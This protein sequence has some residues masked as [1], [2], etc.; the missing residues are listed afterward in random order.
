[1]PKSLRGEGRRIED[2]LKAEGRYNDFMHVVQRCRQIVAEEQK[3]ESQSPSFVVTSTDL[4]VH[5]IAELS[6]STGM[7]LALDGAPALA[8]GTGCGLFAAAAAAGW[9]QQGGA[10]SGRGEPCPTPITK[11][12]SATRR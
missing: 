3:G 7:M 12:T 4:G 2:K 11:A 10:S 5:D 1:M 9:R 8:S 6:R